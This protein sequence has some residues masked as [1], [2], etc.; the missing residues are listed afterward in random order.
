MD[1]VDGRESVALVKNRVGGL[2]SS[3]GYIREVSIHTKARQED[4]VPENMTSTSRTT[5]C[6]HLM[7]VKPRRSDE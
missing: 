7:V 3:Y 1:I 2:S 4:L 6:I 5:A